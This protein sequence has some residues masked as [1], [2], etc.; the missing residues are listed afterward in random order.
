MGRTKKLGGP[1]PSRPSLIVRQKRCRRSKCRLNRSKE[2][3]VMYSN[4]QGVRGKKTS[5]KHV[6]D[7]A[8]VDVVMLAETLTRK[9]CLENYKCINPKNSVGQNVSIILTNYCNGKQMKLYEPN[10]TVNMIGVRLEINGTGLRFHTAHLKQ[11]ST[12]SRDD[13]RDQ[14][15]EMKNQ[16]RSA[17]S[18]R[19]PMLMVFDA[20]VHVGG[21]GIKN[22][23]DNQDW[24]GKCLL[25]LIQEEGLTLINDLDICNGLVTRVDPRNGH[26]STIDLAICNTF[27]VNKLVSMNIDE[28]GMLKL[29][30]YGKKITETGHNTI[31]VK[32]VIEQATMNKKCVGETQKRYNVKNVEERRK[33][34]EMIEANVSFNELFTDM[35]V[36]IN[37]EIE[38]FMKEWTCAMDKSF[39]VVKPTKTIRKGVDSELKALLDEEKWVRQ[40][41]TENPERGRRI[42]AVQRNIAL[43]VAENIES[44]MESKVQKILQSQNPHSKVFQVRKE[45]KSN[46]NLDFPLKDENGV[47]Q[48]SKEGVDRI[49]YNH[50]SKVFAQNEVPNE[51]VWVEYWS[52]VDDVFSLMDERTKR[53]GILEEPT[54]A[55]IEDIIK[56]LKVSKA[57]YGCL[58]IDLVKLGGRKL[59]QVI[60]ATDVF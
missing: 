1:D 36:D 6:I 32:F 5:L 53:S 44:E 3:C 11:L 55:E 41:I 15:D 51:D 33:M 23:S 4:I 47:T 20:N 7:S 35:E 38:I 49:I 50:F 45:R 57:T 39:H 56:D 13:I 2:I 34:Q 48:V 58:S 54:L 29:K 59:A 31:I 9:V 40:N 14:F 16:F 22:C 17:N 27:M 42:A 28:S 37:N 60:H 46:I 10:Q 21:S 25:S 24:G 30:R 18:G 43:K 19:E 8:G 52:L 12:N 26:E